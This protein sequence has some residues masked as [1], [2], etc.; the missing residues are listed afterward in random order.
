MKTPQL[1]EYIIQNGNKIP[2]N[3]Y[4]KIKAEE[5]TIKYRAQKVKF[6]PEKV[7]ELAILCMTEEELHPEEPSCVALVLEEVCIAIQDTETYMPETSDSLPPLSDEAVTRLKEPQQESSNKPETPL[8]IVSTPEQGNDANSPQILAVEA[9]RNTRLENY[10]ELR[11][12]FDM[13]AGMLSPV[14]KEGT[15]PTLEDY[16]ALMGLGHDM[17]KK[18][19]WLLVHGAQGLLAMGEENTME[20]ICASLGLNEKTVYNY[21]TTL[22]FATEEAKMLLPPTVLTEICT[23]KYSNDP[24]ENEETKKELV[25]EAMEAGWNSV[26]ARSHAEMKQGKDRTITDGTSSRTKLRYFHQ[27]PDGTAIMTRECP[28][29][30]EGCVIFDTKTFERMVDNGKKIEM[31]AVLREPSDEVINQSK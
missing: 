5:S 11:E 13:G 6:T 27:L 29:F 15:S 14:P 8:E 16:G 26:E 3:T 9:A 30:T 21:L 19:V 20:Q 24:K 31:V 1:P 18:G 2:W 25:A 12:R 17:G 22:P 28:P 4:A 7:S 10:S 23:R